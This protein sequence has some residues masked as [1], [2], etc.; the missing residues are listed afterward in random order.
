MHYLSVEKLIKAKEMEAEEAKKK[1]EEGQNVIKDM[2]FDY[3]AELGTIS[4]AVRERIKKEEDINILK[5]MH[6]TAMK[7]ESMQQLEKQIADL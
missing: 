3:I 5:S 1:A 6:K 7:A 4:E 2:L